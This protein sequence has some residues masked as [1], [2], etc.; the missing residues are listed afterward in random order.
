MGKSSTHSGDFNVVMTCNDQQSCCYQL[1]MR[2][3]FIKEVP[4]AKV[5]ALSKSQ[6]NTT[7]PIR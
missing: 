6:E 3:G 7:R 2:E 1:E 5:F 4:E